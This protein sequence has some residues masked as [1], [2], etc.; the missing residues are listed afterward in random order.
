M[1]TGLFFSAD[2][3]TMAFVALAIGLAGFAPPAHAYVDLIFV[4]GFEGCPL[5]FADAD[6]DGFGVETGVTTKCNPGAHFAPVAGDCNDNDP[7]T[8]PGAP[9][10][11]DDAFV[12][13]NCDGI[14]GDIAHAVFV[15]SSGGDDGN[16]CTRAQPC[17]TIG[18]ALNL[19]S[20]DPT[21]YQVLVQTGVYA[22]YV[23]L[24][25]GKSIYG[26]YDANWIRGD[27][28][29][30]S[31]AVRI[32]N[33]VHAENVSGNATGPFVD[34]LFI[35]GPSAV[36]P[37]MSSIAALLVDSTGVAFSAVT[38][39]A[40]NGADGTS[41][42]SPGSAGDN[43]V[44]GGRGNPGVEHS[45]TFGCDNNPLP[46]PGALGASSCGNTGGIGGAAGVGSGSGSTGGNGLP[47]STGGPG[48]SGGATQQVGIAG[49][50]GTGGAAGT[51]GDGGAAFGQ[52]SNET[53]IPS[54]GSDG[55]T[56][57]DGAGGGGGGGG[58]GGTNLCDSSGSSGGGGGGGGCGGGNG[59]G[60]TG[61]GGSFALVLVN[62]S[63]TVANT[64]LISRN[65]GLGG[66]GSAGGAGGT[67]G[68]AGLGGPYGGSDGQ[69]DGGNGAPGGKGGDGGDGGAGGGGGGGPSVAVVCV[70]A[71]SVVLSTITY[72]QG[73]GGL[74]GLSAGNIGTSGLM[75]NSYGCH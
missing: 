20:G 4:D 43:G 47:I 12:D 34:G 64:T 19:V 66:N 14:D 16:P 8:H 60:A 21:H 30:P 51:P 45:G 17:A 57:G 24:V 41:P 6:G 48:G 25:A 63:A 38:I 74:G 13:T 73:A 15:A 58:G 23:Q 36:S 1:R 52:F 5:S 54:N 55:L 62:S 59:F 10:V 40:G 27:R 26:G 7:N 42:G 32:T 11:P 71:S 72:T 35:D 46:A 9:D 75:V 3:S 33:G 28:N 67:G 18:R 50:A 70:G 37:G 68:M 53:Y 39:D 44:A 49:V 22:E 69:D 56:G 29:N 2:R 65:G 31:H 61:G